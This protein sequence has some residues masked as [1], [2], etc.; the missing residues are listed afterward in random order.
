MA[1]ARSGTPT[2]LHGA[3]VGV[4]AVVIATLW[5]RLLETMHPE[6]LTSP[7][8]TDDEAKGQIDRAFGRLDPTGEIAAECWREY[9]SKL[10]QWRSTVSLRAALSKRWPGLAGELRRLLGESG[11]IVAALQ[12]AGAPVRFSELDPGID[13]ELAH[14]ALG[15]AHLMRDRFTVLDLAAFVGV[16]R[17]SDVDDVLDA[18]RFVG[19]GL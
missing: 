4:A 13:R 18:A 11:P 12:S 10:S 14:W 6:Q 17:P 5:Q 7:G 2:G 8:P 16:W 1:A 9:R 3:Q 15:N 19:G